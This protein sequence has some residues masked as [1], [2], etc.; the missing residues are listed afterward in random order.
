MKF[1]NESSFLNVSNFLYMQFFNE[2]NLQCTSSLYV[3][4]IEV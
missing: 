4:F 2:S 3:Y 1:S